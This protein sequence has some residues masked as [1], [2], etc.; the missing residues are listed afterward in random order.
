MVSVCGRLPISARVLF[1]DW[2]CE[3]HRYAHHPCQGAEYASV[4][5]IQRRIR[6]G[7]PPFRDRREVDREEDGEI[8]AADIDNLENEQDDER[9]NKERTNVALD[10]RL[11]GEVS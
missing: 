3:Q 8:A 1:H 10:N 6:T 9:R 2:R 5:P 11:E 7:A 4:R